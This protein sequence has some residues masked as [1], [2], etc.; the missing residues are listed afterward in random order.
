MDGAV[1][2]GDRSALSSTAKPTGA[3][4][5][6]HQCRLIQHLVD[7]SISSLLSLRT[8]C[9]A[10]NDFTRREIRTLEVKLTKYMWTQ[11]QLRQRIPEGERPE[12]LAQYPRLQDWLLTADLTPQFIQAFFHLLNSTKLKDISL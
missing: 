9:A 2:R 7:I 4:E 6:L 11:L 8:R 10:S 1:D 12:A 5:A 3:Q